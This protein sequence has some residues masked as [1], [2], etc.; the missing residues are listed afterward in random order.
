MVQSRAFQPGRLRLAR[1]LRG[2]QQKELATEIGVTPGAMSQFESGGVEPSPATV[3]RLSVS[4]RC[5]RAFFFRA[6]DARAH[7]EPFF[8]RRRA[9]PARELDRARSYA[10]LLLEAV[11]VIERHIELP[12]PGFDLSLR[13]TSTTPFDFIERGAQQVRCAWNIPEGPIPNV[14]RMLELHGAVVAAVGAFHRTIDAFSVRALPRP[15]VV[16]C[17]DSGAAAR[18]RFD[19]A[20]ELGHLILHETAVE[21]ND[22]QEQQ[23]RRF[24]AALLMPAQHVDPWLPRRS[25]QLELLEEGS[26]KWGVSMQALLFRAK[27]LGTL[28]EDSFRRTMRRMSAAGWRTREPVELGPPETPTLVQKAVDTLPEAGSTLRGVADE[29][30]LTEGRLARMLSVP[31]DRDEPTGQV[32]DMH[33]TG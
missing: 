12:P 17:S 27:T 2:V 13:A 25:N 6:A 8:R 15:G 26:R 4:L 14:V 7:D 24:A 31:E 18:R 32:L 19:A 10:T 33:A 20:H 3:E 5:R 22:S 29:L 30:G 9:T 23:A 28:S 16:L 21:A 1:A 11:S